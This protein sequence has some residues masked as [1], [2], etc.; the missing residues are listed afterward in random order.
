MLRLTIEKYFKSIG[1]GSDKVTVKYHIGY[2]FTKFLVLVLAIHLLQ[3][4]GIGVGN[5]LKSIVNN[6]GCKSLY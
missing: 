5:T 4:I 1:K 2:F 3:S 6:P